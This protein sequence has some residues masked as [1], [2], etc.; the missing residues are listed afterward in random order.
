M[1]VRALVDSDW[2]TAIPT[3]A[4]I[5][6]ECVADGASV[7]F[8]GDLD[9]WTAEKY[10]QGIAQ[11]SDADEAVVLG[12][13]VDEK[14]VGTATLVLHMPPNQPHR[15]EV[16][17]V[18]VSPRFRRRGIAKSLML[19]VEAQAMERGKDL[20]VLDTVPGSGAESLYAGLGWQKVGEIP[21][22]A[23]SPTGAMQSTSVFY[24]DLS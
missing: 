5:L 14:L 6:H 8:M 12:A 3:L 18:L 21:R 20:L 15:A 2:Q 10:W 24:K 7:S 23:L 11:K 13:F 22:F 1:E 4:E 17:K 9:T 16:S 19:T